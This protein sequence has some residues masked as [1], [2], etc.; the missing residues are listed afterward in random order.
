ML[1]ARVV[2]GP[3]QDNWT[4]SG[5]GLG[6]AR[7]WGRSEVAHTV[8][9][10]AFDSI[11]AAL[12][13]PCRRVC[14]ERL[15]SLAVLGSVAR[16]TQRPDSDIDVLLVIDDLPSGRR[17]RMEEFERI[18]ALLEPLLAQ[19][20]LQGVHTIVSPV[21]K[22]PAELEAGSLLYLDM[23]DQARILVDEGGLL[24]KFL[25]ALGARLAAAGAKRV[26]KG[27]GYYW[28][29]APNFRWGDRIEL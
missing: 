2:A 6:A 21:L 3:P 8:Y 17:A 26:P 10:E 25:D 19:A 22:T 7:P 23:V 15:R 20:R 24:R 12:P 14:G 9:L 13:E 4:F 5:G 16:G 11:V 29:L 28:V 1:G 18:D 27:G